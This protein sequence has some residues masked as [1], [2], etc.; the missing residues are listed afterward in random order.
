MT[1]FETISGLDGGYR[2]AFGYAAEKKRPDLQ[3]RAFLGQ[4]F[5]G[6]SEVRYN[7]A[8]DETLNVLV[9]L[10]RPHCRPSMRR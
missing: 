3:A 2:A 1:V 8:N 9:R 7:A 6:A 4:T 10:R 5:L